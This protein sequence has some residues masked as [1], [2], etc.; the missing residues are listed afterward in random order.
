MTIPTV[1]VRPMRPAGG[2]DETPPTGILLRDAPRAAPVDPAAF[3]GT[4]AAVKAHPEELRWAT[5]PWQTDLWEARRLAHAAGKPLF[6]WAMNG[7][8]LGCV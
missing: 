7:N 2:P 8:P 5:I 6:L 1:P 3:R 4:L